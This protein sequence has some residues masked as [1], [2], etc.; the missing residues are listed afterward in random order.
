LG[1]G[2]VD[3]G[4][5]HESLNM[6]SLWKLPIVFVVENNGWAQFVPQQATAA[7]PD[8]YRKAEAYSMPG[9][10]GDGTDVLEIYRT[11]GEA[12]ERARKGEGPTLLE[13][14]V[15]RWLGHYIGDPQKYRDPKDIEKARKNDPVSK[16]QK[17]LLEEKVITL[18]DVEGLEESIKSEIVAAVEYARSCTPAA[19]EQ[20]FQNVYV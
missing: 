10:V 6:A 1:D 3:Q 16:F 20:A 12:I 2:T 14:R 11:S 7:Q 17:R 18:K 4:N 13:Y 9:K 19:V 15:D 8:I 5:F